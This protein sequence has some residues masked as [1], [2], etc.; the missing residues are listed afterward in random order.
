[1]KLLDA[2][3]GGLGAVDPTTGYYVMSRYLFGWA[4]IEFDEANNLARTA[5]VELGNGLGHGPLRLADITGK[6]VHLRDFS[7][8]GDEQD[9]GGD[10]GPL[11]D[12]LHG[13]LWRAAHAAHDIPSYLDLARPDPDR[14]R[15]VAQSL[16]GKALRSDGETKPR[17][18]QA[19]EMLLGAWSRLVEDNLLRSRP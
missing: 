16:Q 11:I 4:D 9:L 18:A 6:T 15:L 14:L 13:L 7:E 12:V 3:L 5:G 19:C 2:I 8:R 17:E 10:G 1:M